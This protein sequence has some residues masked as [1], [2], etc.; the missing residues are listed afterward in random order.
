[1]NKIEAAKAYDNYIIKNRLEHTKNFTGP[2]E[3]IRA[4]YEG[5]A[6]TV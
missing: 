5:R 1:M 2:E 3:A 6:S 4:I